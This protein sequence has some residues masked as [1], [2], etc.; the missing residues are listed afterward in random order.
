VILAVI[1]VLLRA[2]AA[3]LVL[4][5]TTGLS[6]AASFGLSNLIWR[7]G[8]GYP[9]FAAQLPLYIFIFI[10]ALGV[11]YNIRLSARVREEARRLG[12]RLGTLRGLSV[13]GG[14]ITAAGVVLAATFAALAQLPSVSLVEVGTAVALGVLLD[15]LVVRTVVVPAMLLWAADRIWWPSRR[16]DEGP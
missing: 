5:A 16:G 9:G 12:T 14:V 8:L 11:D 6:F 3:P 1:A 7:Y 10:V 15:T 4:V 13:T 2:I